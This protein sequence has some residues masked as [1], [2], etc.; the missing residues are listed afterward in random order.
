MDIKCNQANAQID[1]DSCTD[2]MHY[3]STA[4]SD[5]VID[6]RSRRASQLV[7]STAGL[8]FVLSVKTFKLLIFIDSH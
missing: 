7:I 3:K 8:V 1:M 6:S 4:K 2:K 5:S